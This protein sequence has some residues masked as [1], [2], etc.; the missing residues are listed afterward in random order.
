MEYGI[1]EIAIAALGVIVACL[2][3]R[4]SK[5][6][7]MQNISREKGYFVIEDTNIRKVEDKDYKRCIDLFDL[8]DALHF[9]LYGNGDVFLLKEQIVINGIVVRAKEPIETFFSI[10]AQSNPYGI[11]LP[12]KPSH[13]QQ[14]KIN[15]EL[16][17]TLKNLTGYTYIEE[18]SL[19][20]E[21][22]DFR[23]WFLKKKNIIFK[24]KKLI[25]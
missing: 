23:K 22:R 25:N 19:E 10:F 15:I 4:L 7:N 16:Y 21:K 18:I 24:N 13:R 8:N 11:L 17:L 3:I 14:T 12:L 6:I 5:Q 1:Y 20:F 2:Q 9:K